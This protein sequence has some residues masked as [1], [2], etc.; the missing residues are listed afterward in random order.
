MRLLTSFYVEST[1]F[2]WTCWFVIVKQ[3]KLFLFALYLH[4]AM[5]CLFAKEFEYEK[6]IKVAM[7]SPMGLGV[8]V[9]YPAILSPK[10]QTK[11]LPLITQYINFA[12]VGN[13]AMMC[14]LPTSGL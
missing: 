1:A 11:F 3:R 10:L 9:A 6:L 12:V 7:E 4:F 8:I 2:V 5:M 14:M 13:I